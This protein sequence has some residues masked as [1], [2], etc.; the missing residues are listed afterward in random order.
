MT[1]SERK[2]KMIAVAKRITSEASDKWVGGW[3]CPRFRCSW[4]ADRMVAHLNE[5]DFSGALTVLLQIN[6]AS[7]S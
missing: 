2:A 4:L 7:Y 3:G 5:N 6:E 1:N